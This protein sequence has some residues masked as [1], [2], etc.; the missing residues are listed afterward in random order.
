MSRLPKGRAN[1]LISKWHFE[2]EIHHSPSSC[3]AIEDQQ[4]RAALAMRAPTADRLLP[5]AALNDTTFVH[6]VRAN[7]EYWTIAT[8]W[9]VA[10][11]FGGIHAWSDCFT[12][13]ADGFSFLEIGEAYLCGD[14]GAA[15]CFA[16]TQFS[17]I[18]G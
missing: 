4:R 17:A 8:S 12:M 2:T 1:K 15:I 16:D 3:E 18:G 5:H 13:G 6:S 7:S 11:V 14:W 10:V 9:L